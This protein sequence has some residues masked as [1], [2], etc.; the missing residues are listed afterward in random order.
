[1]VTVPGPRVP[2]DHRVLRRGE[3][4]VPPVPPPVRELDRMWFELGFVVTTPD[5]HLTA[6]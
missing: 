3:V 6:I 5:H 4:G 2:R 1:M